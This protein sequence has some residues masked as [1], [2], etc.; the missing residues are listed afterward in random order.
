MV[1]MMYTGQLID[2]LTDDVERAELRALVRS[3]V[4]KQPTASAALYS[5]ELQ[6]L[7]WSEMI[8]AR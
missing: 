8:G 2:E 3:V 6:R 7:T 4:E 1:M 5:P